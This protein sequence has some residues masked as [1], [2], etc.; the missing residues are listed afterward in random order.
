MFLIPR[1]SSVSRTLLTYSAGLRVPGSLT[2]WKSVRLSLNPR[3][4]RAPI[5]RQAIRRPPEPDVAVARLHA[6]GVRQP[7]L[8]L[9]AV[10]GQLDL[11][12]GH[13]G[14]L[15]ARLPRDGHVR[16]LLAG[17]REVVLDLEGQG[18]RQV[19]VAAE[20]DGRL[21]ELQ[22]AERAH[23]LA[24]GHAAEELA[25]LG[26]DDLDDALDAAH[27]RGELRHREVAQLNQGVGER[28]TLLAGG[29]R[30]RSWGRSGPSTRPRARPPS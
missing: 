29:R 14:L 27:T 5:E 11:R 16:E 8:L 22:L 4:L 18:H 7:D 24:V 26:G 10:D 15:L 9:L 23:P 2:T 3:S 20:G 13:A 30:W 19:R 12:G 1:A 17:R 28:P 25:V 6:A 21:A